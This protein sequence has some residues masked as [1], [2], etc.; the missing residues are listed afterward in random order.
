[1]NLL[2]VLNKT[3]TI[4][5]AYTNHNVP[6]P[7]AYITCGLLEITALCSPV[8]KARTVYPIFFQFKCI[9]AIDPM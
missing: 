8:I 1:M 9:E 6:H 4:A 3:F 7:G 5:K 2:V